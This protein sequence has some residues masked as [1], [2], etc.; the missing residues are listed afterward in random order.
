M[1]VEDYKGIRCY[2]ENGTVSP[3]VHAVLNVLLPSDPAW[4]D[5]DAL[6]TGRECHA[7]MSAYLLSKPHP[8][9]GE[10]EFRTE[11]A[12]AWIN[13]NGIEIFKQLIELPC[14]SKYGYGGTPDAALR[15]TDGKP[16]LIDWKFAETITLANRIQVETAYTRFAE[17][18]G[19][20]PMIVQVKKSGDV[21]VHK[22]KPNPHYWAWFLSGV[23]V[24]KGRLTYG[25]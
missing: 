17:Y 7:V 22:L 20:R 21:I 16:Y 15:L 1:I 8:C 25:N 14:R 5:D 3:S 23:N 12:K 10:V 4:M 2:R 18:K 19:F 11:A 24:L 13:K 6:E 9:Y